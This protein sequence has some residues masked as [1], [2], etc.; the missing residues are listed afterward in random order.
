MLENITIDTVL[1]DYY[2]AIDSSKLS[3]DNIDIDI[4][5]VVDNSSSQYIQTFAMFLI[6]AANSGLIISESIFKKLMDVI[7]YDGYEAQIINKYIDILCENF[8]IS[9]DTNFWADN[10]P[11][12][13]ESVKIIND[14]LDKL[15][16]I[17]DNQLEA[18]N[19]LFGYGKKN[20]IFQMIKEVEYPIDMIFK[21]IMDKD[22][23]D[24]SMFKLGYCSYV[25]YKN[26]FPAY[27]Y[28]LTK[29][30]DTYA[31]F[32]LLDSKDNE[33]L[34]I[35]INRIKSITDL[36]DLICTYCI[37]YEKSYK[38]TG[39]A[40][41]NIRRL[42]ELLT[43]NLAKDQI[44]LLFG[45]DYDFWSKYSNQNPYG[46]STLSDALL[47]Y[48]AMKAVDI[49][50]SPIKII[51][52]IKTKYSDD[53]YFYARNSILCM[54]YDTF[55]NNFLSIYH[56][57]YSSIDKPK[58]KDLFIECIHGLLSLNNKDVNDRLDLLYNDIQTI[59]NKKNDNDT[60]FFTSEARR[61]LNRIVSEIDWGLHTKMP[62]E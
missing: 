3:E 34:D 55:C 20:T 21:D 18:D 45:N 22:N 54:D 5:A 17:E 19:I 14:Y 2:T 30:R 52:D 12:V 36:K 25:I 46:L 41:K 6:D 42:I 49:I 48:D 58:L 23:I 43:A 1:R 47:K 44:A 50:N 60:F 53:A 16:L 8:S 24:I 9:I 35:L 11:S 39:M 33:E 13:E 31:M 10:T 29:Y 4:D 51:Y 56:E 28:I 57:L 7:E 59:L 38:V 62:A 27:E 37:F 15:H 26:N 32:F 40:N 61:E